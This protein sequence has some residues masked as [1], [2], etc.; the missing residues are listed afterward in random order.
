MTA[1]KIAQIFMREKASIAAVLK[2]RG[3][4]VLSDTQHHKSQHP[5]PQLTPQ[6]FLHRQEINGTAVLGRR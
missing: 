3:F 4:D 6:Q 5:M 2:F 1:L